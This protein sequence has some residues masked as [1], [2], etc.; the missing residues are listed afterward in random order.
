MKV[1]D[2]LS[3]GS[4]GSSSP[5]QTSNDRGVI[6]N[7]KEETVSDSGKSLDQGGTL[8]VGGKE[9]QLVKRSKILLAVILILAATGGA[10]ATFT[11]LKTDDEFTM[12]KEVRSLSSLKISRTALTSLIFATPESLS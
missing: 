9:T 10:L 6:R 4:G 5:H 11:F 3:L 7:T 2:D 12:E 8:Q 1:A